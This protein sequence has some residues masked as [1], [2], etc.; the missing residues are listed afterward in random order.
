MKETPKPQHVQHCI[1]D[2]L[3]ER[4]KLS[5]KRQLTESE[6]WE[7]KTLLHEAADLLQMLT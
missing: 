3:K 6:L 7:L 2:L 1:D 5:T 4:E